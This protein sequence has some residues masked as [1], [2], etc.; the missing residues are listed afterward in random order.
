MSALVSISNFEFAQEEM[1]STS[2]FALSKQH[3]PK[4]NAMA[5]TRCD[6]DN[7]KLFRLGLC[8]QTTALQPTNYVLGI[9]SALYI[10]RHE[11]FCVARNIPNRADLPEIR[12]CSRKINVN[13]VHLLI[14]SP[15]SYFPCKRLFVRKNCKPNEPHIG[16]E[17]SRHGLGGCAELIHCMYGRTNWVDAYL[18]VS[19]RSGS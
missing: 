9:H 17:I 8:P 6:F 3:L 19:S 11:C 7:D 14:C 16:Y 18:R 5:G 2:I 15:N 13:T 10:T 12:R 4:R 1:K